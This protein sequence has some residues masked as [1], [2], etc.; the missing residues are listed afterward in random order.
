MAPAG[1]K[2]SVFSRKYSSILVVKQSLVVVDSAITRF[3][4]PTP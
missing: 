3:P 4:Y 1:E 2:G